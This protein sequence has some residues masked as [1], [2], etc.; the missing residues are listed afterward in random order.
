MFKNVRKFLLEFRLAR[1]LI[2]EEYTNLGS[3][4]L[5]SIMMLFV[6]VSLMGCV[7]MDMFNF[8]FKKVK[9]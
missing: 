4:I 6:V 7:V 2:V 1:K 9:S 3:F 8:M 5:M